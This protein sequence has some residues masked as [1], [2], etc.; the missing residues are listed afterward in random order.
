MRSSY[1]GSLN[2]DGMMDTTA[3]LI[4][5]SVLVPV[6]PSVGTALTAIGLSRPGI[7]LVT[8]EETVPAAFGYERYQFRSATHRRAFGLL[9]VLEFGFPTVLTVFAADAYL[10]AG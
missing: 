7:G 2:L 5:A 1:P 10:V 3:G 6:V 9:L 8:T 4:A